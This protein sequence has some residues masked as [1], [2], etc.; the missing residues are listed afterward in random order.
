MI[1]HRTAL[2]LA[3]AMGKGAFLAENAMAATMGLKAAQCPD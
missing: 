2:R 1:A 3:P